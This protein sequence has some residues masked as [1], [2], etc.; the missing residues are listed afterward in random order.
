[1]VFKKLAMH[2]GA[3]FVGFEDRDEVEKTQTRIASTYNHRIKVGTS[4]QMTSGI[5]SAFCYEEDPYMTHVAHFN[6]NTSLIDVPTAANVTVY[7]PNDGTAGAVRDLGGS[8]ETIETI[9]TVSQHSVSVNAT[10]GWEQ[11]FK[12]HVV[13]WPKPY[14]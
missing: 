12:M 6:Y 8:D 2:R 4:A 1:M 5:L 7:N 10:I 13:V 9:D 14:Q 11:P 3:K